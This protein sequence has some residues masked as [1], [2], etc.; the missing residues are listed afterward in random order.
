MESLIIWLTLGLG[1][2]AV[3]VVVFLVCREFWTWYWK[4][5]EQVELL[6][7]IAASVAALEQRTRGDGPAPVL[8]A[9]GRGTLV[10]PD[11]PRHSGAQPSAGTSA[12]VPAVT[13]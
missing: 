2:L 11:D 1:V 7:S 12:P 5:S 9:S 4:Q 8:P 6:K 3:L 10:F 13:G